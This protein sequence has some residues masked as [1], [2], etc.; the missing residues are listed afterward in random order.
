M[1]NRKLFPAI[2]FMVAIALLAGC[3]P[4][5]GRTSESTPSPTGTGTRLVCQGAGPTPAPSGGAPAPTAAVDDALRRD[6]EAYAEMFGVSVEEAVRRLDL[7]GLVGDLN[8]TL[9]EREA[10]TFAGLW[11]E[12]EPEFRAV[13]AFTRDGQETL[14]PYV[15]GTPLADSIELRTARFSLAEL[16]AIYAEATRELSKLDFDVNVMLSEQNNRVE[17][18]VSDRAWVESELKRVGGHLPEGVELVVVEGGSTARN[19][20]LLLTPPVPGIAFPRQKPTEGYRESMMALASGRLVLEQG[21]LRLE[22]G[23]LPVW[24]P[25]FTLRVEGEQVLVLDG[26]GG[27]AARVGEEVCMG[28]GQSGISDEWVLQQIPAACRGDYWIV[29]SARPNLTYDSDLFTPEV[30]STPPVEA[31]FLR[32]KPALSEQASTAK[33]VTGRLVLYDYQRCLQLDTGGLGGPVHLFWPSDWSLRA[34]DGEVA[35]LDGTGQAVA[36]VGN[37]VSLRVREISQDWDLAV[38]RQ[39][40]NELPCSCMGGLSWL[41]DGIP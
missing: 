32:Y 34:G 26:G 39:L 36:R 20:D 19:K 10:A 22:G 2:L 12:H 17:V 15:E 5:R 14:C 37:D 30:V 6:A 13:V 35:V 1:C 8:A 41:V 7:Q 31:I 23:S 29:G 9:R 16:E 24:P 33:E 28:G 4:E 25:K 11:I 27:V 3:V 18:T 21:C 38:Y 40:V